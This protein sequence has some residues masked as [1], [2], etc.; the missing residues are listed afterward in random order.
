MDAGV[1]H[2]QTEAKLVTTTA[3][4]SLLKEFHREKLAM[5]ERHVAVARYVSDYAFNNT[6]QYIINR[7][8]VKRDAGGLLGGLGDLIGGDR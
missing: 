6:Y 1:Y 3:L 7:E 4:G 8:D 2:L 5:R